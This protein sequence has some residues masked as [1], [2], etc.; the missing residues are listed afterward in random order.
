MLRS[1]P[2][3]ALTAAGIA[4]CL[5]AFSWLMSVWWGR[6]LGWGELV[7][8]SLLLMVA[9]GVG[10]SVWRSRSR[11]KIEDMRDSALW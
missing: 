3:I 9:L 11:R 2:Y 5:L 7:A 1:L 6:H 4:V 10:L 8:A